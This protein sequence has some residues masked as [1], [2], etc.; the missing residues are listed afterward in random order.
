MPLC[1]AARRAPRLLCSPR[2]R[3]GT[4]TSDPTLTDGW[5]TLL[6]AIGSGASRGSGRGESRG[7]GVIRGRGGRG[8]RV[9]VASAM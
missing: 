8:R 1:D 2:Q 4:A 7:R 6:Q 3:R 5:D 9:V